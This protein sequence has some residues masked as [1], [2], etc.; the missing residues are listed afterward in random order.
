MLEP[1]KRAFDAD[2]FLTSAGIGRRTV[3]LH[4]EQIFFLQGEAA[5]S[6]F[7][8]QN[9]SAGELHLQCGPHVFRKE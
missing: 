5:G 1:G 4:E 3:N 9:C 2:A 7:Y 6:I 8:L